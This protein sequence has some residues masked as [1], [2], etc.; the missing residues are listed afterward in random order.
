MQVTSSSALCNVSSIRYIKRVRRD[1]DPPLATLLTNL[2][3]YTET[4]EHNNNERNNSKKKK[5]H[6]SQ[7]ATLFEAVIYRRFRSKKIVFFYLIL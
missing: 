4:D 6:F 5:I 3:L 2:S 1:R 7:S